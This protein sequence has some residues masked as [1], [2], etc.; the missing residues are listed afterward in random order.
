MSKISIA[1]FNGVAINLEC[2]LYITNFK[3]KS[4]LLNVYSKIT[5]EDIPINL[6]DKYSF[7][8]NE[9]FII[10]NFFKIIRKISKNIDEINDITFSLLKE[11]FDVKFIEIGNNELIL[12]NNLMLCRENSCES[13]DINPCAM[14]LNVALLYQNKKV[15]QITFYEKTLGKIFLPDNW[16]IL[17]PGNAAITRHL[18]KK[19]PVWTVVTFEKVNGVANKVPKVVGYAASI[20][21]I[22]DAKK[23]YLNNKKRLEK[24]KFNRYIK[25]LGANEASIDFFNEFFKDIKSKT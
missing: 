24:E 19:G 20:E 6:L 21:N 9:Q 25:K 2:E 23:Y 7:V 14:N 22:F 11:K 13:E 3:R 8:Y 17:P 4:F 10:D 16:E 18:K 15:N 12:L 5:N 1:S